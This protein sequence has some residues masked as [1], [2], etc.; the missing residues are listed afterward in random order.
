MP[1]SYTLIFDVNVFTFSII[2]YSNNYEL[3]M[4]YTVII[5]QKVKIYFKKYYV[6]YLY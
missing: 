3:T 4:G 6:V 2:K 1:L 5:F